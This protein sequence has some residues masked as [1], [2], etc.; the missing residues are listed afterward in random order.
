MSDR[1]PLTCIPFGK[2]KNIP[3]E[4]VPTDYLR[5]CIDN[6]ESQEHPDVYELVENEYIARKR[7]GEA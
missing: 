4:D 5:W 3:I 1:L 2:H 6:L 7:R